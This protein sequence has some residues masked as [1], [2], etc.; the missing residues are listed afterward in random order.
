MKNL[1][2]ISIV[3]ATISFTGLLFAKAARVELSQKCRASDLIAVIEITT[4]K[5]GGASKPYLEVAMAKLVE[6]IKG[7]VDGTTFLLDYNNGLGCPNVGYAPGDRC[8]IF[9]TKLPTGHWET[10]NTYFGKFMITNGLVHGFESETNTSLEAARKE[11]R[12]HL[13]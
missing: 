7:Q 2:W 6:S 11:I 5:P 9:A 10:Y 13:D 12:R 4:T 3:L 1:H 8:L